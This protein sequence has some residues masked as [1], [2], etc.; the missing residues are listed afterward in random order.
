MERRSRRSQDPYRALCFQLER[1]CAQGNL[2]AVVLAGRNGLLVAGAGEPRLCE[3]LSA[4][5]PVLGE[6]RFDGRLPEV[7][8]GQRIGVRSLSVDG[9]ML[10]VASATLAKRAKHGGAGWLQRSA[11]GVQRI[12]RAA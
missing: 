5:A 12:L 9:E 4:V 10:F 8:R 3:A 7:L 2:D 6:P 11:V 1:C